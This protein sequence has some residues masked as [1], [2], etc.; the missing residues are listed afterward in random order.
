[1]IIR[2]IGKSNELLAEFRASRNQ[3]LEKPSTKTTRELNV[4]KPQKKK[5]A[6]S[7]S[8]RNFLIKYNDLENYIDKLGTRD[9]AY[10]FRQVAED[11]GYKYVIANMKK[12][13]AIFK[14]LQENFDVQDI[15]GMIEFLYT[16]EQDYLD[17]DRLSPNVLASRWVNTIY[18]DMQLWVDDKYVPRSKQKHAKKEWTDTVDKS[19]TKASIG[20]WD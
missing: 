7:D 19:T 11:N 12:D 14:R 5:Q 3:S 1:M 18:S 15:C 13:M 2:N 10:Y 17:K 8:Y 9:L 16:S 4:S 20:G 6:Q